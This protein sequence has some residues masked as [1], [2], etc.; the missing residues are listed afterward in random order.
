M[1]TLG[2]ILPIVYDNDHIIQLHKG[3]VVLA[4]L[5]GDEAILSAMLSNEE[6]TNTAY[7][8]MN[9]RTDIWDEAIDVL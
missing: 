5:M 7:K 4:N 1:L 9:E 2:N 6:D 3:K 8:K